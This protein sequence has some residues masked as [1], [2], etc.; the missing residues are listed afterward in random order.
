ME[1]VRVDVLDVVV[2]QVDLLEVQQVLESVGADAADL[3]AAQVDDAHLLDVPEAVARDRAQLV[4][5]EA[6]PLQVRQ[7]RER[8]RVDAADEVAVHVDL[9]QHLVRL[10]LARVKRRHVVVVEDEHL[11]LRVETFGHVAVALVRA[12]DGCELVD[13]SREAV[14]SQSHWRRLCQHVQRDYDADGAAASAQAVCSVWITHDV[15]RRVTRHSDTRRNC[16]S[17]EE[18]VVFWENVAI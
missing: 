15:S 6:Q 8:V 12:V 16:L 3:V 13:Y 14:K 9:L 5:L 10:E 11:R 18:N 4:H 2:G 1:G 7:P 17:G